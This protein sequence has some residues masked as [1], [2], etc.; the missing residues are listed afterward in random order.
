[1]KWMRRVCFGGMCLLILAKSADAADPDRVLLLHSFAC[2]LPHEG[3]A[4]SHY[5]MRW[6]IRF[7]Q[8]VQLADS[9][10]V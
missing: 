6:L 7:K 5:P 1:M 4:Q 8:L 3:A 9:R 10:N 2:S